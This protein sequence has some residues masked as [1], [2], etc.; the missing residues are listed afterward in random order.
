MP[1][2]RP[3]SAGLAEMLRRFGLE[4]RRCRMHRSLSQARLAE[5]SGVSQSTISRLERG[6]APAAAMLKLVLLSE[7]LG[8]SFPLGYCPHG[9]L[10]AWGRLDA[11]GMPTG[12]RSPIGSAMYLQSMVPEL[13]ED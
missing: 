3:E 7:V 10:C 5:A 8:Y 9:H 6:K 2:L 12:G 4:L 13:F 11:D 1:Y